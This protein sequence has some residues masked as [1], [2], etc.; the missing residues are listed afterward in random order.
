MYCIKFPS[1][2]GGQ[3]GELQGDDTEAA[4]NDL[5]KNGPG[6]SFGEASGLIMVK[7]RLLIFSL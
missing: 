3:L 5:V 6:M 2:A 1:L 7:V 4:F